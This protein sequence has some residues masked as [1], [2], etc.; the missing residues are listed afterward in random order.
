MSASEKRAAAEDAQSEKFAYSIHRHSAAEK[1]GPITETD[2]QA[3]A[4]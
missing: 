3:S 4:G 1:F 2:M